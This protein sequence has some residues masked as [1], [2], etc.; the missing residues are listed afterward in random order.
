MTTVRH[1]ER[2]WDAK[3]W[4]RLL[5]ELLENRAESST[6]LEVE[7][8]SLVAAAAMAMIRLDELGQSHTPLFGRLIRTLLASQDPD[9]GWR[10]PAT[11]ALCLRA[12][13]IDRG[14]GLAIDRGLRYLGTMQKDEGA[15]P[16][17]PI[18][19]MG[20]DGFTSA[21][22]MFHLSDAPAFRAAVR[23]DDA[24]R[25][26]TRHA[27]ELD[28]EAKRLWSLASLRC[29]TLVAAEREVAPL[30]SRRCA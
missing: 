21:L 8:H 17:E 15:W 24:V 3:A 30:W 1:I 26:F 2:L 14:Q 22:V 6:R 23:F 19:R 11:T 9:G 28:N 20:A 7:V 10:D 12:L 4:G 5:R 27:D 29:R 18:R 16:N 25:W 13:L